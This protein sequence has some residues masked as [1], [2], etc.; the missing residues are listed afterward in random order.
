[1]I[2]SYIF[3]LYG[4]LVDIST[5][6]FMPSLWR[7]LAL[8]YSLQDAKYTPLEL[9]TAY[10]YAVEEQIQRRAGQL[11]NVC[12]A[13]VEP[14]ILS[15][16]E[17]LYLLKG[18][19][20]SMDMAAAAAL[21]FRTLSMKHIRLYPAA[22]KVIYALKNKGKGVYLLSNAQAAFTVPELKKLGLYSLFDGVVLSSVVG[23]KKPDKAIFEHIL[24]QYDLLPETCVM[25]GNDIEADMLGAA[26]VGMAGRY[27]HTNQSPRGQ[28]SL[29]PSCRQIQRLTELL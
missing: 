13:Y 12:K 29:P 24:S 27:I 6:E 14:D 19:R 15:V 10:A 11:P 18:V 26:S 5:D 21:F 8:L 16:F 4:T 7:H 3:D 1:M 28:A 25:I 17:A 20:P 23:I 9:E 22:K 2:Q